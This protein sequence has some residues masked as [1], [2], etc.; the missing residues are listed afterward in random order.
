[1][2]VIVALVIGGS[3]AFVLGNQRNVFRSKVEYKAVFENVGGL[4][5]GSPVRI[6]GVDV[7]T[8]EEVLLRE[9]GMIHVTM[10]VVEEAAPLV[11]T[12]SVASIGNKGLLGDK[13]ID[14]TSGDGEVL[15]PGG[16]I[17]SETPMD[18]TQYMS[19][20]GVIL[21]DVERTVENLRRATEPLGEQQFSDDL[22]ATMHNLAEVSRMAAEEDGTVRR[23][24]SDPRMADDIQGTLQN[25]RRASAEVAQTAQGVRA[26]VN[27][28]RN[29]DGTAHEIVYGQEGRRLV[30]NLA[31]ATGEMATLMRDV[32]EGD[33]VLH[34]VV[35]EREGEAIVDNLTQMSEDLRVIVADIRAGRGTIGG[36]I[37]DP[38]IYEDVKRLVGDL[39][40]NDI[41]RSL[42]RY[43]IRRDEAQGPVEVEAPVEV[44]PAD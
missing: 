13:L 1:L 29:G 22:R 19:K 38:S 33:G 23:L 32:R 21:G 25:A 20:A 37:A 30:T 16:T 26:I 18:L 24:L 27:E 14:I 42:V 9:D 4:R 8:V 36:L 31:D 15:P 34:D 7:G 43:S 5:E 12:D 41:L 3:L 2:F 17:P 6:A 28:V 35:Y 10:G 39:Q 44:E 40:R 11:R